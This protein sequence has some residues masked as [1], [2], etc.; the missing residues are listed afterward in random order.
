MKNILIFGGTT[1]GR[2]IS[3][4]LLKQNLSVDLC[5][6][7]EYGEQVLEKEKNLNVKI[8]RLNQNQIKDLYDEKK[9]SLVIDATHPFAKIISEN[10]FESLKDKVQILKIQRNLNHLDEENCK[11]FYDI[12]SCVKE[13][14][15]T[16]G[17]ILLTTGSKNLEDFS[18]DENLKK[19]L[20]VRILPSVES[21]KICNENKIEGK[22]II[23]MQGP[24]SQEM[25]EVQIEDYKIKIL[26]A[27]ESGKN[28]GL[29]EKILA[30]KN[31][32]IKCF[33]IKSPEQKN[34][35]CK[36]YIEVCGLEN[37][38]KI[39]NKILNIKISLE[40]KLNINLVGIG[41]GNE[42]GM[43]ICAKNIIENSDYI[44]GAPRMINAVKTKAKKFPYY[45]AEDVLKILDKIK[46]E[47]FGETNISILFSGDTGFFSGAKNL[48]TE[49]EKFYSSKQ[50]VKL[51]I[52]PGISSLSYL[53]SK[54]AFDYQDSK[55]ISLHG[56][57]EN[58]WKV[59]M[60]NALIN[61]EKIFFLTSG[62]E[63][64]YKIANLILEISQKNI[65]NC[66]LFL[67]F[68]LSY[69]EEKIF[70]LSPQECFNIKEN[71]LYCGFIIFDDLPKK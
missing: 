62:L 13:L 44:F 33:I 22:Q 25:N 49:L 69:P 23:A 4:L 14:C 58:I 27:K 37:T 41:M 39:L 57:K 66:K 55:I 52:F 50:N 9:Y 68:Q 28:G 63:D 54:F 45:L 16:Q 8:G 59:K 71:G 61:H 36:N 60:Q 43:T 32:N 56:T 26:L 12:K 46:N 7:T 10:I 11:Y 53:S 30:S 21:L 31:K 65:L 3:K 6:A 2:I 35:F 24:F 29:D 19:R 42:E 51:K 20:I 64:I 18:K 47:N 38:V 48:K 5:V 15:K 1:E 34:H 67:G 40:K 17:N 70:I